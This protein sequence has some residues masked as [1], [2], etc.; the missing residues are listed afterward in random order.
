MTGFHLYRDDGAGGLISI[1]VDPVSVNGVPTLTQHL[2]TFDAADTG[3]QFRFR[4][5]ADNAEGYKMSRVAAFI[6]A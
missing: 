6:I 1:E 5:Q 4:L 3:K 2:V